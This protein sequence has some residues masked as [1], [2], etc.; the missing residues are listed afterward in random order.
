MVVNKSIISF[1]FFVSLLLAGWPGQAQDNL[2]KRKVTLET[3]EQP[4]EGVLLD[5]SDLASF[6]FSYDASILSSN[7]KLSLALE[8]ES[9]KSTLDRILPENIDYKVSGNHLILLKKTSI[10]NTGK[11]EKYTISG[12]VYDTKNKRALE[13]IV[14]YEVSNLV[15]AVTDAQGAF[16]MVVP[17]EFEHF[18]LSF[19]HRAFVDT[20]IF[21]APKDQVLSVSL[22]PKPEAQLEKLESLPINATASVESLSFVQQLVP[23]QLFVRTQ[24]MSLIRQKAAQISFLPS[25]GTNLKMGGLIEN[26]ISINVLAGYAYGVNMFEMGGLFNI[27]R[28][29]VRGFQIV[30]LGN[31]VGGNVHGGQAA[32]LFNHNRGSLKG[33]QVSGINNTLIDSLNGVQFA[34]ISNIA[35]G[36]MKGLQLSGISNFSTENVQGVQISGL[37]NIAVKDV[38]ALQIAGLYNQA[39]QVRGSQVSGLI[40][41]A[42]DTVKS[43]QVAGLF[44][45]A[46]AVEM[47]QVAGIAN[48]S[49][50]TVSGTQISGLL[51]YAP[52]VGGSQVALI[53]I[54][55]SA[56]GIPI[57]FFSFVKKGHHRLEFSTTEILPA[58]I[59]FKTGVRRFYNIFTGGIGTWCGNNNL[60]FG[61]G[62][63]TENDLNEKLALN[64]ELTSNIISENG[65]FQNDFNSLLRLDVNL[66]TKK[67]R[68]LG[69]SAGPSFNLLFVDGK[70]AET[71][72]FQTQLAPYTI[73]DTQIGDALL[74]MW[75]GG[76]ATV[77]W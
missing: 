13:H 76:K 25:M 60:S 48:F 40:N 30:G 11:K 73:V 4:L 62:L 35:K 44:N 38:Q 33:T 55:D 59:T 45:K 66:V 41:F 34:G 77:Y 50:G 26:N 20:I 21:V 5:M 63:G 58:N 54:A 32:G 51:N 75:I 49:E 10:P 69:F 2:L 36:G 29:D 28:K 74:Q 6:T 9:V 71:G 8:N 22:V 64:F 57:G 17:A 1:L 61:Y 14:I 23:A 53:N 24:N 16:T 39:K 68:A 27:I 43:V 3:N 52:F 46:K 18:G 72:E 67:T 15:S 37:V 70:D 31:I 12:H 42:K 7:K 65:S 19:N 47:V 56:S